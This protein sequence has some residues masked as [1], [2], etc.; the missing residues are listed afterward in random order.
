MDYRFLINEDFDLIYNTFIKAFSD[1]VVKMQPGREQFFEML[2]R[3]GAN[4][5]ISV[6]AYDSGDLV[7][8]NLNGIDSYNDELTV[9]DVATGVIAANITFGEFTVGHSGKSFAFFSIHVI[10]SGRSICMRSHVT[11]EGKLGIISLQ[12][13][14]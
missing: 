13:S 9:Y 7:G 5:G 2:T 4:Y 10:A 12:S 3:R 6:G 14:G 8:F 1:Y 11:S